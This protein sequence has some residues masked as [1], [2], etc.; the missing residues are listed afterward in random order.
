METSIG[1]IILGGFI[2]LV[3]LFVGFLFF[4][5]MPF[6]I[7]TGYKWNEQVEDYFQLSDKASSIEK[8][9]EY[10]NKYVSVLKERGLDSGESVLFFTKPTTDLKNQFEILT[11]LQNRMIELK[12]LQPNSLEYQ[13]ALKQITDSE[14]PYVDTCVFADGYYLKKGFMWYMFL[15]GNGHCQNGKNTPVTTN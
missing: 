12:K 14:Y 1:E 5:A 9:T 2:S 11:S 10:L 6:S 15:G 8:K 13:Q 3:V 4:V 7:Y